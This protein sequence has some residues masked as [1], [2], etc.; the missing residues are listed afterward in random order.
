MMHCVIMMILLIGASMD[1]HW[2]VHGIHFVAGF[3]YSLSWLPYPQPANV[4]IMQIA[5][6]PFLHFHLL[7]PNEQT[8]MD[9]LPPK[10]TMAIHDMSKAS[11]T[12][13]TLQQLQS[14]FDQQQL[15]DYHV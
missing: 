8:N 1:T 13:F 2:P 9:V 5:L 12:P 6:V 11:S 15:V 7:T 4:R 14:A 10:A 3:T